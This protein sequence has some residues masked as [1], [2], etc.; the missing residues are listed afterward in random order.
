MLAAI[1]NTGSVQASNDTVEVIEKN[2]NGILFAAFDEDAQQAAPTAD[3]LPVVNAAAWLAT[4]PPEHNPVLKDVFDLGDKVT[5]LAPSKMRKSFF[6]MQGAICLAAGWNFLH[7]QTSRAFRVLVCQLEIKAA[8]YHRRIKRMHEA[9][10]KPEI[11][12]RL[13]I[14]N[15]RGMELDLGDVARVAQRLKSEIIMF[16]PLYKLAK[17]DENSAEDM[18]PLLAAFDKLAEATG[19]AV[20]Y[21]HHDAK[22]SASDRDTRDRGAGSGVLARDY[23]ACITLTQHRDHPDTAVVNTLLRNYPPREPFCATFEDGC[24]RYD[25]DLAV[26]TGKPGKYD[27]AIRVAIA[28]NPAGSLAD[29]AAVVGCDRSTVKRV[30]DKLGVA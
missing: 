12:T 15:G 3:A 30:K 24:F 11:E 1:D 5:I 6:L 4:E 23:D 20:V 19:A 29:I 27:E 8:H 7:W 28:N 26:V 22:G 14:V 16:D 10:G 2:G 17:G 21:V 18:K 25:Y 9:L 13:A